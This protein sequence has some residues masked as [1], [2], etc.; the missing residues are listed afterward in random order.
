MLTKKLAAAVACLAI[1]GTA[2]CEVSP[3]YGYGPGYTA[4]G[5]PPSSGVVGGA[6]R[7]DPLF[8]TNTNEYTPGAY[9]TLSLN[10]AT[11]GVM[12]YNLCR[13]TI[14]RFDG[15]WRPVQAVSQTCTAELRRLPPGQSTTFSFQFPPALQQGQ[16]RVLT[17]IG[18][19]RG[20]ATNSFVVR[21]R[22]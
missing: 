17:N 2:G 7:G 16:Y 3:D 13:S 8:S 20:I 9:I 1:V 4:A 19:G 10:N 18:G 6:T 11:R 14:E 22:D 5:T 12:D 21:A 15:G